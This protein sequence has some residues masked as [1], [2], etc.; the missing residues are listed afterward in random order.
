[1]SL[2]TSYVL[3]P[4]FSTLLRIQATRVS[5]SVPS[6]CIRKSRSASAA[7]RPL[8][9]FTSFSF[10]MLAME[11]LYIPKRR[12]SQYVVRTFK[13]TVKRQLVEMRLFDIFF[14]QRSSHLLISKSLSVPPPNLGLLFRL[15][16]FFFNFC[17]NNRTI[18]DTGSMVTA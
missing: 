12:L 11:R 8:I 17:D 2:R 1:M 5:I 14:L 7:K 15:P 10:V 3:F 13:L 16:K 4:T 9:I 18:K 6:S